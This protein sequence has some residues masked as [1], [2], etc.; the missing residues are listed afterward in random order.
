MSK[1]GRL[2]RVA[3]GSL[4]TYRITHHA[5]TNPETL[6]RN[7]S[8]LFQDLYIP[9]Y[10]LRMPCST[11]DYMPSRRYSRNLGRD[12]GDISTLVGRIKASQSTLT[13]VKSILLVRCTRYGQHRLSVFVLANIHTPS[14]RQ[15]LKQSKR[16]VSIEGNTTS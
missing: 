5:R 15:F 6:F 9:C 4:T 11:K 13:K 8:H 1:L 10:D 16:G 2:S 3:S 12:S 14:S 7:S